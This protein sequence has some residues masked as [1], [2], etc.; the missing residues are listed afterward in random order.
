MLVIGIRRDYVVAPDLRFDQPH[1]HLSRRSI[2]LP[3]MTG[4]GV[5][6]LVVRSA[7]RELSPPPAPRRRPITRRR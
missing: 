2:R 3:A 6:V 5:Y 7:A 4:G 1:P